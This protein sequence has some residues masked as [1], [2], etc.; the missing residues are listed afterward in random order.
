MGKIIFV[1]KEIITNFPR[2]MS[3]PLALT[4]L[5]YRVEIWAPGELP[6]LLEN[7]KGIQFNE[8]KFKKG[9]GNFVVK[10]ITWIGY[11]KAVYK[12]LKNVANGDMIWLSSADS[13]IALV[14][15]LK[16]VRYILQINE[17]Y[18]KEFIYRILLYKLS[19]KA[20]SIVVP[21]FNRA[22]IF[23]VWFKLEK[24]PFIL[25]NKSIVPDITNNE[26]VEL[27]KII[28]DLEQI[29]AKGSKILIYQGHISKDRDFSKLVEI[30]NELPFKTHLLLVGK[31][32]DMVNE[33][34]SIYPYL[35]WIPFLVAPRHLA[36]TRMA[37]LG[38][39]YYTPDSLNNIFCAPNKIWEFAKYGL[40][41]ISNDIPGMFETTHLKK[42][43]ISCNFNSK[44]ELKYALIK[45]FREY[46]E[47]SS[48]ALRMYKDMD[49]GEQ[50]KIIIEDS[51]R[52]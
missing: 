48:N 1:S 16:K 41:I 6:E 40:P 11:R 46:S 24:L 39:I 29:K 51:N 22:N 32:W 2:L 25:P 4:Q 28:L 44:K 43:G 20:N 3:I 47:F 15:I 49:Y 36:F 30:L 17:L 31:D 12:N 13:A 35:T 26:L 5:G 50:I 34:K 52:L 21:E 27:S 42:C 37:D 14:G 9:S 7:T 45:I 23:R 8:L 19:K 10:L 18:E 38:I 33:Y